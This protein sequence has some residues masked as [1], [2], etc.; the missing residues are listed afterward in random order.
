MEKTNGDSRK[1]FHRICIVL[2]T[3]LFA[4]LIAVMLLQDN[5]DEAAALHTAA[6]A[7]IMLM[8]IRAEGP[9]A[10]SRY[11]NRTLKNRGE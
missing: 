11:R 6:C 5:V 10:R 4:A 8:D 3:V 7:M 9:Y 1:R 2:L